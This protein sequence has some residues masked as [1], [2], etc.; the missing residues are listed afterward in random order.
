MQ[1]IILRE[2]EIPNKSYNM[3]LL[4][5]QLSIFLLFE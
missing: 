4:N 2:I 5:G 3:K 1:I